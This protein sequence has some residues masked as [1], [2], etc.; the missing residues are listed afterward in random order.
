MT[1]EKHIALDTEIAKK[2]FGYT[3]TRYDWPGS[4][5]PVS[6]IRHVDTEGNERVPCCYS[7]DIGDAWRVV[8]HLREQGWLVVVKEM[9]DAYPFLGD[10]RSEER[11]FTR[12]VCE[13]TWM[14][15]LKPENRDVC[16]RTHCTGIG[17]SAPIAICRAALQTLPRERETP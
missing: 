11:L 7:S 2:L 13:L 9:P 5:G 15:R 12:A 6:W 1:D 14:D 8:E 17:D 16:R 10:G 4:H 3:V